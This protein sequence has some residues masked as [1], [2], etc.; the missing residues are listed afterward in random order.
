MAKATVAAL[1]IAAV[2][3]TGLMGD[4]ASALAQESQGTGVVN[5][6]GGLAFSVH[7]PISTPT[8]GGTSPPPSPC[9]G[10]TFLIDTKTGDMCISETRIPLWVITVAALLSIIV[11]IARF[12]LISRR[13]K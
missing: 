12:I 7:T 8:N 5:K 6:G 1:M 13:Q 4:G 2:V 3:V 11:P 10:S 9:E